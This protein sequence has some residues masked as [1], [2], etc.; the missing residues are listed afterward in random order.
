MEVVVQDL[1]IKTNCR[2]LKVTFSKFLEI[3]EDYDS[4]CIRINVPEGFCKSDI[5][6]KRIE[7]LG[8]DDS[9]LQETDYIKLTNSC[10]ILNGFKFKKLI[11]T[12]YVINQY[13]INDSNQTNFVIRFD[14]TRCE[15]VIPKI[16]THDVD[17]YLR[18]LCKNPYLRVSVD[19]DSDQV[20][21]NIYSYNITESS[22]DITS[23]NFFEF[24]TRKSYSKYLLTSAMVYDSFLM[25]V[26]G[27]FVDKGIDF[28]KYPKT[29]NL[30]STNYV[31]YRLI[32]SGRQM[33][34]RTY[35]EPLRYAV[36]KSSI[37]NFE[38]SCTDIPVL[39]DFRT[40]YQNLDFLTNLTMFNTNDTLGRPWLSNIVWSPIPTDF[41]QE[42]D[43]DSMA[44]IAHR[45]EFSA[46]LNYYE[47][48]DE[49]YHS[50]SKVITNILAGDVNVS[51]N[52]SD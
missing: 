39:D 40:K 26:K 7:V 30:K 20:L 44:N 51:K 49:K 52:N 48:Y 37:F 43:Q 31:I 10:P 29:D 28:I 46:T 3:V 9:P 34:R 11:Q 13:L 6:D 35:Q 41:N 21:S 12:D 42:Y 1:L 45:V 4:S 24:N 16:K 15:I 27:L 18:T 14:D 2:Y 25:R 17:G 23:N 19:E 8:Y 22:R 36:Q 47:V 33:S 32:D 50:I 5:I 38:F